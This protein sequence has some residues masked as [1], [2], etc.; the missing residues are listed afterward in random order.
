M[1]STLQMEYVSLLTKAD[2]NNLKTFSFG[3]LLTKVII[4]LE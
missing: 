2:L 1:E 3:T 4:E